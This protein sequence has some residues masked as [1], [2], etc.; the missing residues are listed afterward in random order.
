LLEGSIVPIG[1]VDRTH[2]AAAKCADQSIGTHLAT[3]VGR[4]FLGERDARTR[5]RR[6]ADETTGAV[7]G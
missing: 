3:N 4:F 5:N 2:A 1:K 7:V 6:L